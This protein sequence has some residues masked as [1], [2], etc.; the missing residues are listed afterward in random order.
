MQLRRCR[1]A[2]RRAL[3]LDDLPAAC[4]A[5]QDA[6]DTDAWLS[7]AE[8]ALDVLELDTAIHAYRQ[9]GH[10]TRALD[11]QRLSH[12][13]DRHL[14]A[15]HVLAIDEGGADA[16]EKLFF[17]AGDP[18]AALRLR[19]DM[20]QWDRAVEIAG[21]HKPEDRGALAVQHAAMLEAQG[22]SRSALRAYQVRPGRAGGARL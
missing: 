1:A 17:A 21:E 3:E 11:L 12:I 4:Q 13:E 19:Q 18:S 6:R 20:R 5:A 10:A 22:D 8:R 16:A 2:C 15:G 7:V 14:L 9:A